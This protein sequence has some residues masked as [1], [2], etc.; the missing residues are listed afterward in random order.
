[1]L[2]SPAKGFGNSNSNEALADVP[3]PNSRPSKALV[4]FGY[5]TISLTLP[6]TFGVT[7]T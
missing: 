7:S 2:K 6:I 3:V 4:S 1:M 5:I